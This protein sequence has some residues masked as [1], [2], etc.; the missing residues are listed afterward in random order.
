MILQFKINSSTIVQ[1]HKTM[2]IFW[3]VCYCQITIE[4]LVENV[5]KFKYQMQLRT[6]DVGYS[7]CVKYNIVLVR[8]RLF[9]HD[10]RQLMQTCWCLRCYCTTVNKNQYFWNKNIL[11]NRFI[12]DTTRTI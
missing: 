7:C 4:N 6:N 10:K 1:Y 11:F 2:K 12:I 3:C 9:I 5:L 8:F